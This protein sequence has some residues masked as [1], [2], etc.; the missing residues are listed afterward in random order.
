MLFI[1]PTVWNL[2]FTNMLQYLHILGL[3]FHFFNLPLR[4][5]GQRLKV[6]ISEVALC[7]GMFY[8]DCLIKGG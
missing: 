2:E 6:F 1:N 8:V 5:G 3:L 7:T 4:E